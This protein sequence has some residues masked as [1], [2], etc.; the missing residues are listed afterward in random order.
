MWKAW[1][2]SSHRIWL[3]GWSFPPHT[4]QAQNLHLRRAL[5]R[6][7]SQSG[8]FL[9]ATP[10]PSVDIG[11]LVNGVS[12]NECMKNGGIYRAI[13]EW[14]NRGMGVW[15][16][17]PCSSGVSPFVRDVSLHS[18]LKISSTNLIFT[19][20]D[21]SSN[22]SLGEMLVTLFSTISGFSLGPE[23]VNCTVR[24]TGHSRKRKFICTKNVWYY[25]IGEKKLVRR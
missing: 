20:S 8:F 7:C 16:N 24:V 3:P 1:S 23:N 5:S 13:E 14:G 21:D 22:F 9:R 18:V 19:S 10:S 15:L 2:Q 25:L 11:S 6:Q 17:S 4:L 12:G